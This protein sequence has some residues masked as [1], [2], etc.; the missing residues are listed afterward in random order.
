MCRMVKKKKRIV[1][2]SFYFYCLETSPNPYGLYGGGTM[3]MKHSPAFPRTPSP[4]DYAGA[5]GGYYNPTISGASTQ[6]PNYNPV[7]VDPTYLHGQ[8]GNA[9]TGGIGTAAAVPSTSTAISP[10]PQTAEILDMD[11]QQIF[12]LGS[13]DLEELTAIGL[14]DNLSAN[15]SLNDVDNMSMSDSITNLRNKTLNELFPD[16][17]RTNQ[18]T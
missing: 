15:L 6:L 8:I 12:E 16:M 2:L 5:A 14:S 4:L 9:A 10:Q 3:T 18:N 13:A 11:R 7:Y 1:L 17:Y